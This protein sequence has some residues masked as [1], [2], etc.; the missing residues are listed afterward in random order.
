[1]LLY[2]HNCM[3]KSLKLCS[4]FTIAVMELGGMMISEMMNRGGVPP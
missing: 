3:S 1:M 4:L 2:E